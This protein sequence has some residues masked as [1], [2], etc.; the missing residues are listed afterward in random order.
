MSYLLVIFLAA[1]NP[2]G[3]SIQDYSTAS[4]C[5]A[6]AKTTNLGYNNAKSVTCIENDGA[7]STVIYF[8]TQD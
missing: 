4:I 5:I 6:A 7:K 8:A 3:I 2:I 1:S